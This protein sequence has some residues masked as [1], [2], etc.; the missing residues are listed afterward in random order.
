MLRRIYAPSTLDQYLAQLMEGATPSLQQRISKL[1]HAVDY[2]ALSSNLSERY[3]WNLVSF[4]E[5]VWSD[6]APEFPLEEVVS[7]ELL[8][9]L[10]LNLAL[11]WEER[12]IATRYSFERDFAQFQE[13]MIIEVVNELDRLGALTHDY[14]DAGDYSAL[15]RPLYLAT[16]IN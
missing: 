6:L 3:H 8:G 11:A 1:D 7:Q 15:L 12:L 4:V 5:A 13:V 14:T 10:A 16:I 2:Y 9:Q